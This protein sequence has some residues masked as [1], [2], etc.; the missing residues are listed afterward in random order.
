MSKIILE[1]N[2]DEVESL[3][4]LIIYGK[5]KVCSFDC[6][7]LDMTESESELDCCDCKFTKNLENILR[8]IGG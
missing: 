1:L 4:L 8:K 3:K 6:L 5:E 2:K 7:C